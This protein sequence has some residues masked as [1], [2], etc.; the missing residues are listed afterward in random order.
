MDTLDGKGLLLLSGGFDSPV[1]GYLLERKGLDIVALHFSYEPVT[2]DASV[3]KAA[4]LAAHLGIRRLLVVRAGDAFKEVVKHCLH[5]L[6]FVITKRLMLRVASEIATREAC[7]YLIT[8]ESLG[9]V[10]SQTLRNL[11]VINRAATVH[12]LRPLIGFDKQQIIDRAKGIGTYEISVG[13]ELCDILGPKHPATQARAE[14]VEREEAKLDLAGLVAAMIGT[15]R[16][17][18]VA[19]NAVEVAG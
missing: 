9:Q 8:G 19:A 6:Y 1:A 15:V 13:P 7:G 12:V 2:D 4:R 11:D 14:D 5:K 18:D 10:S 16:V 17:V 3:E